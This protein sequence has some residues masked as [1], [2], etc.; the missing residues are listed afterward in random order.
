MSTYAISDV[1]GCR[2]Q[3]SHLL[4]KISPAAEDEVWFLG[5]LIDRGP[6]S[7]ELLVWATTEAPQN[8][9]FLLGN[10]E[11]MAGCVVRRDPEGLRPRI[12]DPW[13][14]GANDGERTRRAL[15]RRTD[16]DWRRDVLA[17]WLASLEP[18]APVTVGDRD[19][20]L[21]HAGFDP[22]AWDAGARFWCDGL[23]DDYAHC[24]SFDVGM[25][26][27]LQ[28]EQDMV[29]AR[30]GWLDYEG[31]CPRE[32]VFGHTPTLVLEGLL[33]HVGPAVRAASGAA[34]PGRIWHCLGRHDID[35]GCFAGGRLAALRL[36]DMAEFYVAGKRRR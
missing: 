27:G 16:A 4:D 19:V 28:S 11:D 23:R 3:L 31:P 34:R 10:H 13:T 30:M 22:G 12:D 17:P 33:G 15:L 21:V 1:H 24:R 25:G 9:H 35:C 36:D 8:F 5:D 18:F 7:A 29:W 20:L 2:T 14:Y 32:V 6:R 26:F